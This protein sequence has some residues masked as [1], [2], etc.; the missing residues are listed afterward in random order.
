MQSEKNS[1]N[2]KICTSCGVEKP[3]ED[4]HFSDK[5]INKRQSKCK[6]CVLAYAKQYQL[7]NKEKI[8]EK[9]KNRYK[10]FSLT[11][12]INK[13]TNLYKICNSCD[14]EKYYKLFGL[15]VNNSGNKSIRHICLECSKIVKKKYYEQNKT[16]ILVKRKNKTP[17]EKSLHSQSVQIYKFAN[18]EKVLKHKDSYSK[19][20]KL[21]IAK[22]SDGTLTRDFMNKLF[23][24]AKSCP[25]CNRIFSIIVKKS[26]DHIKPISKGGLHSANN[27][28]ICC[29]ACN[30]KKGANDS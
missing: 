29:S 1:I 9:N 17:E 30:T 24:E 2:C 25:D 18:P 19:N 4:Y 15:K 23:A 10:K 14:Q 11:K 7:K 20:R 12:N 3:L 26:L 5:T 22:Q 21:R 8:S 13:I 28:R 16:E 27:V 6:I